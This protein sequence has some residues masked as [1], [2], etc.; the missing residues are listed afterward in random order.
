MKSL[1]TIALL[2]CLP[3]LSACQMTGETSPGSMGTTT[4][5]TFNTSTPN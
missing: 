1:A 5:C 3:L 2:A 4:P